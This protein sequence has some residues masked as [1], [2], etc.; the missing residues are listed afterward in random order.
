M[1]IVGGQPHCYVVVPG[2]LELRT[3]T[4]GRSTIDYLEVT[5]GLSEG[6]RIVSRFAD[7]DGI[8][9]ERSIRQQD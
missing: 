1:S 5:G 8:A 7:V 3:I 4:T 6:E 2:G 9:A